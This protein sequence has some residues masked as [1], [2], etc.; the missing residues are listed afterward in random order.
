M[1]RKPASGV[2]V[3]GVTERLVAAAKKEGRI[4]LRHG[5]LP[6]ATE[7]VAAAFKRRYGIEVVV[8]R[9]LSAEG[10]AAF[11]AEERA[12]RHIVDVH[13]TTDR[14]GM[15]NLIKEG[16]YA[17]YRIVNDAQFAPQVKIEGYAYVPYWSSSVLAYNTDKL[18]PADAERL[19][20]GT[21]TGLIDPRFRDRRIGMLSPQAT[22]ATSLWFWALSENPRYG[23][24]FLRAVAAADPVIFPT[25]AVGEEALH[26]GEVDLL[27]GETADPAITAFMNGAHIAWAYPD[28]LPANPTVFHLISKAAPH[29]AAA[30]LFVAWILSEDGA[31]ALSADAGRETTIRANIPMAP[32]VL[33]RLRATGW[34]KPYPEKVRF[35]PTIEEYLAREEGYRKRMAAMFNV[36]TRR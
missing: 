13:A 24:T 16:L 15:L 5:A 9:R 36:G 17:P 2:E 21:W 29:P 12:G 31:K 6:Q 34:W 30:R 11:A 19:F 28:V 8:E 35:T 25:Q 33:E 18:R 4:H 3:I 10:T 1:P 23:E 20:S 27:V 22:S 14:Q 26:A 32:R 7:A